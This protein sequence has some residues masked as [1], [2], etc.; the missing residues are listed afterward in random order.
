MI[1]AVG[2]KK[3]DHNLIKNYLNNDII[4]YEIEEFIKT[5]PEKI[6]ILLIFP[7]E[8]EKKN[9]E[10]IKKITS[11]T[12]QLIINTPYLERAVWFLEKGA[13]QFGGLNKIKKLL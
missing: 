8:K 11:K 7:G 5:P 3:R 2:F 1:V 4:F 12:T 9:F 6:K 13:H 10:E